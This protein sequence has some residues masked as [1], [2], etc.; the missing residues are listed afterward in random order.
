MLSPLPSVKTNGSVIAKIN[1]YSTDMTLSRTRVNVTECCTSLTTTAQPPFKPDLVTM[2]IN[3]INAPDQID[4]HHN[5]PM[6]NHLGYTGADAGR[7]G[8]VLLRVG[9]D[10]VSKLGFDQ[11]ME[12]LAQAPATVDLTL[13]RTEYE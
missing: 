4:V 8:D 13:S 11:V 6:V 10:D 9:D 2:E 1:K 7:G 3:R 12:V 5:T